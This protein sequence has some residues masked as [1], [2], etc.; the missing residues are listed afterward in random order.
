MKKLLCTLILF[1][2]AH[3]INAQSNINYVENEMIIWLKPG[4]SA[5]EFAKG[6]FEDMKPQ[7]LLSR[8][9][10]IWLFELTDGS[11]AQRNTKMNS[12]KLSKDVKYVQNNHHI[13]IRSVTPNDTKYGDQWAP[14]KIKLPEAWT[15]TTGGSSQDGDE[16]VIAII[17]NEFYLPHEDLDFWKNTN[18]IP[19]NGIDDDGNGYIDDYDGWNAYT[20]SGT[21]PAAY[22]PHGTHVAGIAGAK[23]NNGIG[24]SGVNW[25]VKTMPIVGSTGVESVA[26]EAYGY[27]LEM[28]ALYNETNGAEGAFI[29]VAN[30]SFGVPTSGGDPEDY[31][32][33]CAMYD[34]LGAVG[35]LSCASAPNRDEDIDV[36]SDVP[37]S[38]SSDFL[39]TV[40]NTN[41]SDN[42]NQIIPTA[43]GATT[44][45][46][47]APGSD[48]WSTSPGI[49]SDY[50]DLVG[51]S[52]ASP[53]VA[54]VVALMYAA[55]P[56]CMIQAYKANP[57][58]F[59]LAVRQQLLQGADAVASL[60]GLVAHGRLNALKAIQNTLKV[61]NT[62][63]SVTGP[64]LIC[65]NGTFT[66]QDQPIGFP[67]AWS[68]SNPTNLSV[69]EATGVATR[70]NNFNGQV[71]IIASI[72]GAC[73]NFTK[74]IWVGHAQIQD[75]SYPSSM[76]APYQLIPL[77]ITTPPNSSNGYYKAEINRMGGGYSHT[78]YG[79]VM[80]FSL[81]MTGTFNIKVY[82][83]NACGWPQNFYP[84]V[85]FCT[86]GGGMFAVY[87]N[88]ASE[89]LTIESNDQYSIDQGHTDNKQASTIFYR[90]YG[91]CLKRAASLVL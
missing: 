90:L 8:R 67:I 7:R 55:M 59:A 22:D 85:F 25:N 2:L 61:I 15:Y 83:D 66:L 5:H 45:D 74:N 63:P 19:G 86:E 34:E 52:H 87:P 31:P 76:V 29:V 44:V 11:V 54:G 69:H 20:S 4:V 62:P 41:Q 80:E 68:S 78:T 82:A 73:V 37:T 23:G 72:T 17:D 48:I 38:C 88:P 50:A 40:T 60:N 70:Q 53:H 46:I 30:S 65:T 1:V 21:M 91:G 35:V 28:R 12:L 84:L 39:I 79:N 13:A 58:S 3:S 27:V 6:T 57:A 36:I 47:G 43:Y 81:P 33:W 26:V 9:L 42:L 49:G 24:I 77:S 71:T 75:I 51:T 32:I 18:E 10:N 89:T 16:I 14:A 56:Q 64:S